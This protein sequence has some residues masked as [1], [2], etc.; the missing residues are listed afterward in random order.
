MMPEKNERIC[1]KEEKREAGSPIAPLAQYDDVV[2]KEVA[3]LRR[4]SAAISSEMETLTG[5]LDRLNGYMQNGDTMERMKTLYAEQAL[6]EEKI[7]EFRNELPRLTQ[8]C[9]A[10]R[11]TAD[12]AFSEEKF[13]LVS[14]QLEELKGKQEGLNRELLTME[15]DTTSCELSIAENETQMGGTLSAIAEIETQSKLLESKIAGLKR[16]EALLSDKTREAERAYEGEAAALGDGLGKNDGLSL[17]RARDLAGQ[18]QQEYGHLG[19][20]IKELLLHLISILSLMQ[21]VGEK[22]QIAVSLNAEIE[23]LRG[24]IVD[25]TAALN[26]LKT[27][28][29]ENKKVLSA[30]AIEINKYRAYYDEYADVAS[31]GEIIQRKKEITC[32]EFI[33]LFVQKAELEDKVSTVASKIRMLKDLL[34]KTV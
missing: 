26:E 9:A 16:F 31:A 28:N 25:K 21:E 20:E 18:L 8:E 15:R 17:V 4:T 30:L 29:S 11:S 2:A 10:L 3:E 5:E 27:L 19:G 14:R 22:E 7:L 12:P 34:G 13:D 6:Q 23:A 33:S 1:I 32:D 24:E